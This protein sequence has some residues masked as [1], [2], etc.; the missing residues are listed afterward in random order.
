MRGF[1]TLNDPAALLWGNELIWRDGKCV[2]RTTSG[3]YGHTLGRSVALGWV[4]EE[5]A[6]S[7]DFILSGDN[8]VEIAGKRFAALPHLKAPYDP[9]GMRRKA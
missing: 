4:E 3:A 2:G 1:H 8:Y 7:K 9:T 6:D 5:G